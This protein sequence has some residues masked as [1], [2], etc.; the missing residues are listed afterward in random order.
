LT[1]DPAFT[2]RGGAIYITPTPT[3]GDTVAYE[4]VSTKWCQSSGGTA[5]TEW[6]ADT[7]TSKLDEALHVL[8]LIWRFK[9]AKG[10]EYAADLAAF[11]RRVTDKLMRDGVKPRIS[12]SEVDYDRIPQGPQ[13]PD[14]LVFT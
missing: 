14:T 9:Q 11:E 3:A 1:V 10:L 8:D 13:V 2:V 6:A 7:D 5:Q 4:Y 12:T